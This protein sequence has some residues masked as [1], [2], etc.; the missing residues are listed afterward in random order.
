[1][2]V[3]GLASARNGEDNIVESD[4]PACSFGTQLWISELLLAAVN[5]KTATQF[6]YLP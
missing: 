4:L 3:T 1:M 5:H 2:A 6:T